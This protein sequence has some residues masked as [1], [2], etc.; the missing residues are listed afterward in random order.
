M[1]EKVSK[2]AKWDKR[3]TE[4]LT[5][6]LAGQMMLEAFEENSEAEESMEREE[7]EVVGT[8]DVGVTGW[9]QSSAMEVNKEGEDE[10]VVV[11]EVKRC[12][13]WKWALLSPLKMLRKRV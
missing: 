10:V 8:E 2:V 5:A 3:V 7:S 11:E 6:L 12:E 4:K 1:Q 9:T 13:M